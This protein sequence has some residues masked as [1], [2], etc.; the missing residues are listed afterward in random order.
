MTGQGRA[1]SAG[2]GSLSSRMITSFGHGQQSRVAPADFSRC[3]SLVTSFRV[4]TDSI[5]PGDVFSIFRHNLHDV[6]K[7]MAPDG[8][9]A[10]SMDI[11]PLPAHLRRPSS[12][13]LPA[14]QG[15]HISKSWYCA[16]GARSVP[17]STFANWVKVASPMDRPRSGCDR[18][19][20]L[21]LGM[22]SRAFPRRT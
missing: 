22:S 13:S 2:I 9:G 11:S 16:G 8:A 21:R 12:R 1:Y 18:E 14:V 7:L 20:Q 15:M 19:Q 6:D 4:L 17:P 5:Q 3:R 10:S